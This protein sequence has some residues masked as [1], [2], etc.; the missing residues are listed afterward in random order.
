MKPT[1]ARLAVCGYEVDWR[2]EVSIFGGVLIANEME[3]EGCLT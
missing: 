3:D 1:D 2:A